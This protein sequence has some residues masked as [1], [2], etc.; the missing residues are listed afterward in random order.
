MNKWTNDLP[1]FYQ[2]IEGWFNMEQEYRELLN[3]VEEGGTFVELGAW[4]G[5]SISFL[6]V[7]KMRQGREVKLVTVDKFILPDNPTEKKFYVPH[8]DRM[9]HDEFLIN[10]APISGLFQCI[11]SDSAEASSYFEN[12][13]VD[14]VF[15]D[16]SHHY[17]NVLR[18]IKSW[19]PKIK[20]GGVIAGHDYHSFPGVKQ[21]VEEFFGKP[22]KIQNDCWFKYL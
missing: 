4:L 12:E 2:D 7:E 15:V 14:V 6:T 19:F 3:K 20:K 8:T 17:P 5:K 16:A 10:T 22:D 21:A 18:D 11:V 13:S 1:H 9:I